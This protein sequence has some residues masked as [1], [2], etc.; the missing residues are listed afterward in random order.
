MKPN[1]T[2]LDQ[3]LIQVYNTSG[4]IHMVKCCRDHTGFR[5]WEALDYCA[6]LVPNWRTT[7]G[8]IN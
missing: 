7:S 4:M 6:S 3:E 5:L 8:D 2:E 1:T